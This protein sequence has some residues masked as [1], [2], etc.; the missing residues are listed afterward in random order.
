MNVAIVGFGIEGQSAL[1][2][3][4]ALGHSV[5]VCDQNPDAPIPDGI[6]RQLGDGYLD[7]LS[8][9]ECIVRSAGIMPRLIRVANPENPYILERVTSVTNEFFARCPAPII[10]VTGTKGKG[11]TS[12]LIFNMLQAAGKSAFL[13]GNIGQSPLDFLHKVTPE[14]VVVLELSSFQLMDIKYSPSVGVCL[15]VVPEH[16][17]W[18]TDLNEYLEA[19]SHLFS[20]QSANDLAIFNALSTYS[21]QVVGQTK[22][23]KIGFEVPLG[24]AQPYETNGAYVRGD[25]IYFQQNI[26]CNVSD[27]QLLGRHNLENISAAITAVWN[28]INGNIAAIKKVVSS[29]GGLEHRLQFVRE[30]H[31]AS[32]FN[33]SFSTTPETAVAALH[34]FK[35]PK[36]VIVGGS[37]KGIPFDGLAKELSQANV[38]AIIGIGDTGDTITQLVKHYAEGRQLPII[39]L[40]KSTN[41]TEIVRTASQA[42]QPGDVVLLSTGCASFGLFIDYKD[43]GNQFMAAVQALA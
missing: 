32:Y 26:I 20:H 38:R 18:H 27:V 36:V 10:G 8:R 6:N 12:T 16:L 17:D 9:F 33:D 35:E 21:Q 11:T 23:R 40:G 19:K 42:A 29:F 43:R 7:K 3:W 2:Y 5:T 1:K 30:Y 34:A 25:V 37:D 4:S 15:M 28:S 31:G 24:D 22:A 14:S 13:G 41:M 39:S